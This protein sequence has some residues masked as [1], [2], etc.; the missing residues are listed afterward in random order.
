MACKLHVRSRNAEL[1]CEGEEP[2]VNLKFAEFMDWA[3]G[4]RGFQPPGTAVNT[5]IVPSVNGAPNDLEPC[6]IDSDL[7]GVLFQKE[8]EL[9]VL[10]RKPKSAEDAAFLILL[11]H[12]QLLDI[13]IVPSRHLKKCL[14]AS[15]IKSEKTL[16]QLLKKYYKSFIK[17]ETAEQR[18]SGY[19]LR[20]GGVAKA[21]RI[22]QGLLR[23]NHG[24]LHYRNLG[25]F[26][27]EET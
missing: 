2:W 23:D 3:G 6:S 10:L 13:E 9:I 11:A 27:S 22:A 25:S 12:K 4:P 17:T 26:R 8:D 1:S 14:D 18:I 5:S 19:G 15:G 16:S 7:N 21:Q 24:N 20:R